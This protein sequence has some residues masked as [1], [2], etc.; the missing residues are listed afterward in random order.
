MRSR[1]PSGTAAILL[2]VTTAGAAATAPRRR[3]FDRGSRATGRSLLMRRIIRR[4][5]SVSST[6]APWRVARIT[7]PPPW[8]SGRASAVVSSRSGSMFLPLRAI[9]NVDRCLP[10]LSDGKP[11][12]AHRRPTS[13]S[14]VET[15]AVRPGSLKPMRR[16]ALVAAVALA[17]ALT[18]SGQLASGH[19]LPA[20]RACPLFPRTTSGTCRW[21]SC[22]SR[23]TPTRSYARSAPTRRCMP[24]S[25]RASTTAAPSASPTRSCPGASTGC[26]SASTTRTNPTRGPYPIPATPRS[27]VAAARTRPPRDHRRR[28]HPAGSTSSTPSAS[29]GTAGRRA[30]ARSGSCAPTAAPRRLDLGRRRRPPHPARP[31]PLRRGRRGAIDHALR[32]TCADT[33]DAFVWPA[34]HYAATR[35]TRACR[36]WASGS[37]SRRASTS[38][39]S[40]AR[41]HLLQALKRYGMFLADNGSHWYITG[42]PTRLEQRRP[43][44]L[45]GCHGSD[46]EAV[47]TSLAA[48]GR[49][50]VGRPHVAGSIST[51][52]LPPTTSRGQQASAPRSS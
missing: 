10:L 46:F 22:R 49:S 16:P 15:A 40:R 47:D 11:N 1:R 23:A 6:S 45:G 34:R 13:T 19:P 26:P 9:P 39:A 38:R 52:D 14:V 51:R 29:G 35:P 7:T 43:A 18:T 37:A 50:Q 31:R 42:A 12:W 3:A 20:A 32:F 48:A 28:R 36:R 27:R 25:A 24:T 41:P 33:R 5:F 8:P 44:R 4:A 30:R 21:T 17:A 2:R